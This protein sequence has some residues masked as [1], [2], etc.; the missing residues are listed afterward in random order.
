M[1]VELFKKIL[2]EEN[3]IIKEFMIRNLILDKLEII[4]D[5][6]QYL[7]TNMEHAVFSYFDIPY[8]V[9]FS[10]EKKHYR[11]RMDETHIRSNDY[12]MKVIIN[13]EEY[14]LSDLKK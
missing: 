4:I 3:L 12:N 6:N 5:N 2:N 1:T 10:K 8:I 11:I 14:L 7:I 13:N 9:I